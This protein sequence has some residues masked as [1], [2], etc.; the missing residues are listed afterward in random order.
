VDFFLRYLILCFFSEVCEQPWSILS[1]SMCA[2]ER[3]VMIIQKCFL[4]R[5]SH[6]KKL[7]SI[8]LD[9]ASLLPVH[10]N[11]P[12][13]R[14]PGRIESAWMCNGVVR[15]RF[16]TYQ[17]F[18]DLGA[19]STHRSQDSV[20]VFEVYM[21]ACPSSSRVCSGVEMAFVLSLLSLLG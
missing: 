15:Q 8:P 7:V 6:G 4:H 9:P 18:S 17:R 11:I 14:S 16:T 5:I 13:P 19:S 21:H 10:N 12:R 20:I 3:V 2:C 1:F